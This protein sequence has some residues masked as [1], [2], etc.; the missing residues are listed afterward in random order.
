MTWPSHL[1]RQE[2]KRNGIDD[3]LTQTCLQMALGVQT[4]LKLP[5][6][7]S[8]KHL[9]LLVGVDYRYL[10]D[11]V[12]RDHKSPYQLFKVKKRLGGY[13]QIC[14]PRK[15]ILTVQRWISRNVLQKVPTHPASM[16]YGRGQSAFECARQH[17][18]CRWL[19]KLDIRQFFESITEKQVYAIFQELGYGRLISFEMARLCTRTVSP[20]H[21]KL[22]LSRWKNEKSKSYLIEEYRNTGLGHLPQGAATSPSLSN[23]AMYPIDSSIAKIAQDMCLLYTRYADDLVL[24]S[25]DC[26]FSRDAAISVVHNVG[27]V[28]KSAGLRLHTVKTTISPPGA[29][30]VV[31]GLL[32]D[33]ER[34]RL[35]RRFKL[36]LQQHVYYLKKYGAVA[37]AESRGFKSIFALQ[38]HVHGLL[39]YAR[40]VD[41][42]FADPLLE[43]FS[44]VK[45]P[46]K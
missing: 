45:W 8:L 30:K 5:A 3:E 14:V 38:A 15:N 28:L 13:R 42:E 33:R 26:S 31:L 1:Y 27:R 20:Q 7:L 11:V 32:V 19:I 46:W 37:H 17:C 24:S 12:S 18:G 35:P 10:R 21:R 39:T 25:D 23:L 22:K 36:N 40:F 2:A 6:V 9:S 43:E 4:D 34:P 16:A 29:R 41:S 44:K